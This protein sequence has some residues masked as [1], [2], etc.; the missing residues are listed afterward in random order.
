MFPQ[1]KINLGLKVLRK[2]S[3]GYHDLSTIMYPIPLVDVLEILPSSSL[4]FHQTGLE[5]KGDTNDNLIVKAYEMMKEQFQ[6]SGAYIH[7]RKEIPMGAGL[8]G[9]S[10]DGAY[11]LVGFNKL[12]SLG[13]D[14][15]S[16]ES[17]A[18]H[19]G[20]DCPFFIKSIP[21]FAQGRGEVLTEVDLD[22]GG[23]YLV[24]VNPGI[25]IGTKEAYAGVVPK[26]EG[27]DPKTVIEQPIETWKNELVNDF[28]AS[29]FELYPELNVIKDEM[30]RHGAIYSSMSGSGSTMFGLF[31]DKPTIKFNTKYSTWILTL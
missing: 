12:F 5:I 16:L 6:L 13:M 19:L 11:S 15:D 25:H 17:M 23:Y 10:S 1:A 7:L 18:S 28:E 26:E 31:K 9:G 8:G 22:L 4:E 2:R 21:Q 30:Y 3:D 29:I 27:K 14:N 24:L 20:S